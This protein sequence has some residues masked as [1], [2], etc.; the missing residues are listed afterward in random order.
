MQQHAFI[1]EGKQYLYATRIFYVLKHNK[2]KDNSTRCKTIQIQQVFSQKQVTRMHLVCSKAEIKHLSTLFGAFWSPW[3]GRFSQK[4]LFSWAESPLFLVEL[5]LAVAVQY[6][7]IKN[8][9]NQ[10]F[11]NDQQCHTFFTSQVLYRKN[12]SKTN[13]VIFTT[14]FQNNINSIVFHLIIQ[15]HKKRFVKDDKRRMKECNRKD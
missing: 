9:L 11:H 15:M 8:D 5:S 7:K 12:Y 1:N 3:K 10:K 4:A 13:I 6:K 2:L 14:I